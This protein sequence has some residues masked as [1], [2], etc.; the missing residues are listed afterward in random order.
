MFKIKLPDF[1]DPIIKF[2]ATLIVGAIAVAGLFMVAAGI[3]LSSNPTFCGKACHNMNPEY[4]TWMRSSHAKIT[5]YSCH[6]DRSYVV[7]FRNKLLI[8]PIGAISSIL[9]TYEKPINKD[10]ELSQVEIQRNRCERC[11][12][13]YTRKF[14]YSRGIWMNHQAHLAAGLRCTT[15]H[16]RITH[17]GAENYE[18]LKSEWPEAKGFKYKN[19][20]TMK[21]G[22]F[23]CHSSNPAERNQE[24]LAIITNGKT[25]PQACTTCHTKDF[26]LPTGH[27]ETNWRTQH[28]AVAKQNFSY[29][30]GCHDAGAKFDNNG[31]PW[32]TVCH[33][34]SKVAS[35]KQQ[36]S[37]QQASAQ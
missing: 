8:D 26:N 9:N 13:V 4:Q 30:F 27:A 32:C 6:G 31:K 14:T 3:T 37:A 18:P 15:C 36:E 33:D 5:C 1:K 35:F 19:F 28:G 16:N 17:L 7:F 24:T 12:D 11:H 34:A 2:Q 22:C 10:D 25:P 29:C 23:R 21:Q 20:L